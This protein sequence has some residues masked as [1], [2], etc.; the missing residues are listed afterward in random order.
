M[1]VETARQMG[2]QLHRA[3]GT[4]CEDSGGSGRLQ[5]PVELVHGGIGVR[6]PRSPDPVFAYG[7]AC[8]PAGRITPKSKC[9]VG[10]GLT[11]CAR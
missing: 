8:S 11:T 3:Q 2:H 4:T 7:N 10:C 1:S 5:V 6:G 9:T